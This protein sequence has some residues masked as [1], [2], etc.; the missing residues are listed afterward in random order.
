MKQLSVM[1]GRLSIGLII[2]SLIFSACYSSSSNTSSSGGY[3]TSETQD[4]G[5]SRSNSNMMMSNSTAMNS[6]SAPMME[7]QKQVESYDAKTNG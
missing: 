4:V 3:K 1:S 6:P 5:Y 2:F 7:A